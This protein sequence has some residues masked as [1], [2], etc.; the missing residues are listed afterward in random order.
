M[1]GAKVKKRRKV[2]G[3]SG[4][5]ANAAI[6][7]RI[8]NMQMLAFQAAAG[9]SLKLTKQYTTMPSDDELTFPDATVLLEFI[10]EFLKGIPEWH[11]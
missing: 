5:A 7:Q 11:R 10:A 9:A 8:P 4:L 6:T 1:G 2:T 3:V